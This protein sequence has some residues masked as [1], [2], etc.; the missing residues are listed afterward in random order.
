MWLKKYAYPLFII[1]LIINLILIGEILTENIR[2]GNILK[3]QERYPY[4]SRRIFAENRNDLLIYFVPLREAMRKYVKEQ[5]EEIGVY[6]EYLPSGTSIGV[7]EKME[8]R[9]ASL[10]KMPGVMAVY[11]QI[12]KGAMRKNDVLAVKEENINRGFG[13]LW[14][15][16]SGT[17]ITV[18]EAIVLSLIESD[19]TA[20]RVLA[21]ALPLGALED[22]FNNLDI[23]IE[24]IQGFPIITPKNY[25]S[26]LRSL[27]L[28]S[29]LQRE[30]ANEILSL[31]TQTPFNDKLVAGVDPGVKV[32][33]KIGTFESDGIFSDCGIIYI[34]NRPY[35]L[36]I[37]VRG[38][39]ET[40][41]KHMTLLSKMVFGYV[42]QVSN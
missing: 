19:N 29:Y 36:C 39:N 14:R 35:S 24:Q 31:L 40:A 37:M 9:F 25:T 3:I 6:F 16:G 32:A 7:N 20:Y 5:P 30:D 28:S 2:A 10:I 41:T 38:N 11:K 27:Y 17:K 12:E 13:N 18:E 26:I 4:L 34:P 33:H 15:K 42:V 1:S 23:T 8:V 21:S 22:V